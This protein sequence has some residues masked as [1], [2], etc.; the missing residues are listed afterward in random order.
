MH[1]QNRELDFR[2]MFDTLRSQWVADTMHVSS[3]RVLIEHP[4]YQAII[5]LG[6]PMVPYLIEDLKNAGGHWFCALEEI[7][8]YF[9]PNSKHLD[10]MEL[11]KVWMEWWDNQNVTTKLT[12]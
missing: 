10:L 8:G 11:R 4:A 7:T 2:Y 6:K 12:D 3:S 9:L 1:R 5:A